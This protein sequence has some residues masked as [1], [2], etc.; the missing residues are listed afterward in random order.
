M[1]LSSLPAHWKPDRDLMV[2]L[3]RQAELQAA[4]W[5]KLGQNRVLAIVPEPVPVEA[6][7]GIPVARTLDDVRTFV[8]SMKM[9]F[10]HISMRITNQGGIDTQTAQR[11]AERLQEE[12]Q[13]HRTLLWSLDK[14]GPTWA[15]NSLRNTPWLAQSPW[16]HDYNGALTG[17]PMIVVGA[18]PSLSENIEALKQAKGKAVI[19]AVHRALESLHRAGIIPDITI[20]VECR[21]VKHQFVD[22]GAERIAAVALATMVDNNLQDLGARRTLQYASNFWETWLLPEAEREASVVESRGTVSHSAVSLGKVWGCDPIVL[23]GQDLAF[24]NG[25]VYHSDGADGETRI[26]LDETTGLYRET[27]L[28]DWRKHTLGAESTNL[29]GCVEVDAIGGGTVLTSTSFNDFRIVLE[30]WANEWAGSVQL[31]NASTSGAQIKGWEPVD[32]AATL[33]RL[34]DIGLDVE[35]RLQDSEA[36]PTPGREARE[37]HI[38]ENVR[39]TRTHLRKLDKLTNKCLRLV[40]RAIKHPTEENLRKL[41][42]VEADLKACSKHVPLL[43]LAT[44][45]QIQMTVNQTPQTKDVR[46]AL[47]LSRELYVQLR[48]ESL[49]LLT[50]CTSALEDYSPQ[51]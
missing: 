17:V 9:P 49:R 26:E 47:R 23:V 3:G 36:N 19:V 2:V 46:D 33:A 40:N 18:G 43:N 22:V 5:K 4:A 1:P 10:K 32:L 28:S 8:W 14:L 11:F 21:D 34:P 35:Q 27:G 29:F 38:M 41:G 48:K 12:A 50:A 15:A 24:P 20:A 44:Q 45:Y 25:Q 6:T 39:T 31:L 51:G 30:E 16:V 37:A 42:P 13:R 7:D